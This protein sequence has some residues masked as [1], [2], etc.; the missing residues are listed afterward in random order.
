MNFTTLVS[1]AQSVVLLFIG[2]RVLSTEASTNEI[3]QTV[4]TTQTMLAASMKS[5]DG[6]KS[7]TT[8]F[9]GVNIAPSS[10]D[11]RTIIREELAQLTMSGTSL[12]IQDNTATRSASDERANALS[13]AEHAHLGAEL[14]QSF[15]L[16]IGQGRISEVEM[17][18]LQQK[19]ARLPLA[20]RR[21]ALSRLTTALNNGELE[22][23]L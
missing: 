3:S 2:V 4:V 10:D 14:E 8:A 21:A 9:P 19:I 22:G 1:I 6:A 23:N 13:A 18:T 20:Q 7:F 11:I 12:Q 16:Y 5:S 15:G 17:I